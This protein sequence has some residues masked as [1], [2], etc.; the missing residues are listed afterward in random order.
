MTTN[1]WKLKAH[2]N[3]ELEKLFRKLATKVKQKIVEKKMF[4]LRTYKFK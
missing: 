1:S 3:C 4:K 2:Y